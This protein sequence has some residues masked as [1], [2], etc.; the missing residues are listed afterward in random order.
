MQAATGQSAASYSRDIAP[1]LAFHCNRCHGDEGVA[2]GLDTTSWSA[3][4][5]GGNLGPAVVAGDP[6]RSVLM[7]FVDGRRGESHRMPLQAPPLEKRTIDLIG[8]WISQGAREDPDAQPAYT[9]ALEI[10]RAPLVEVGLESPLR[11]YVVIEILAAD[12][13]RLH[14]EAAVIAAGAAGRWSLRRAPQW[15]AALTVR[16]TMRYAWAKPA[17]ATLRCG[18]KT[19]T[20]R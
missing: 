15:P 1:V 12:G 3:L 6:D 9:L 13:R 18:R 4:R 5:A 14:R 16:A 11:A 10:A 17:G 7:E 19:V 2:S 20:L 8:R